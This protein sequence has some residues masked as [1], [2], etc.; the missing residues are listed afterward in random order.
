[1]TFAF[2]SKANHPLVRIQLRSYDL[3]LDPMTLISDVDLNILKHCL[4]STKNE[5]F[6]SWNPNG[7]D[8]VT[9]A[10]ERIGPI[11]ISKIILLTFDDI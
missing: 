3:D 6:K 11:R 2:Q 7:K 9:Y 8:T 5:A 10:T 1:M 4:L